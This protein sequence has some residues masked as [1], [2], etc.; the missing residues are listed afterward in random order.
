MN[1][2]KFIEAIGDIDDN[3]IIKFANP[4][5]KKRSVITRFKIPTL[6]ASLTICLIIIFAIV[7]I[8]NN[9]TTIKN[10][11][12]DYVN[13]SAPINHI[14]YND[15]FYKVI[16]DP[17]DISEFN[18]PSLINET[19]LGNKEGEIL[20][21]QESQIINIYNVKSINTSQILIAE[22]DNSFYYIV[23]EE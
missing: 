19:V 16:N 9:N 4:G 2:R 18:L 12:T 13:I 11:S 7:V 6:V 1:P 10:P 3:Y 5:F 20:L 23:L 21:E 15:C 8:S 22:I 14:I 17:E